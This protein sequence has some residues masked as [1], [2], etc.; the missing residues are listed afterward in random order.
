MGPLCSGELLGLPVV[1]AIG[2]RKG[3]YP[4]RYAARLCVGHSMSFN[5]LVSVESTNDPQCYG[6]IA[7]SNVGGQLA[8][9]TLLRCLSDMTQVLYPGRQWISCLV[10][11]RPEKPFVYGH[12]PPVRLG[13]VELFIANPVVDN[14]PR[15]LWI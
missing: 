5:R 13:E 8:I 1:N 3:L 6:P 10:S 2:L 15:C 7:V 12:F 4:C 9:D 11:I 14:S